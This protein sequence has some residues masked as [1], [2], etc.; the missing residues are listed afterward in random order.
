MTVSQPGVPG[1]QYWPP[2]APL[3]VPA[4]P[5]IAPTAPAGPPGYGW[6]QLSPP[7]RPRSRALAAGMMVAILL[8]TAALVVDIVDL[9]RPPP[10]HVAA[11]PQS[12]A[13]TTTLIGD[14]TAADRALCTAIAPLM[15]KIDGVSNT[16]IRLGKAG[17][18][19]RDNAL[20]KFITD[21]Q[22]WVGQVQPILDQRPDASPYFRRSLQRFLDDR[23]LLV[24]DMEPGPLTSYANALWADSLGAYSGP[25][26]ICDGVGVQW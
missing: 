9:T 15:A 4:G 7:P 24:A 20:P 19:V 2:V 12:A 18:P 25:L 5:A 13:P 14:T 22:D 10:T 26:Q 23:S 16:Y 6:Y 11:A 3:P 8:A 21:T 1:A 17:S